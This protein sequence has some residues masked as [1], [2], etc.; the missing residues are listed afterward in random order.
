MRL[1]LYIYID[2]FDERIAILCVFTHLAVH[3]TI[4]GWREYL[5]FRTYHR[6]QVWIGDNI[7][8]HESVQITFCSEPHSFS[9]TSFLERLLKPFNFFLQ[10]YRLHQ[11]LHNSLL[12]IYF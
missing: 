3:V 9:I 2:S 1:S 6:K 4:Y 5:W 10:Q 8:I 12:L 11:F 7:R